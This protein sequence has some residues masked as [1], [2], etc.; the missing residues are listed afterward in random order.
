M[1]KRWLAARLSPILQIDYYRI[2]LL[3]ENLNAA[4]K[5]VYNEPEHTMR[6]RNKAT[7]FVSIRRLAKTKVLYEAGLIKLHQKI[8]S[9]L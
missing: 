5:Y 2:Q 7:M 1:V 9:P 4:T 8:V 3:L 6:A